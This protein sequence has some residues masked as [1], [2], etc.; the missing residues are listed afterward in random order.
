MG[1]WNAFS[2]GFA[3]WIAT[4]A[5]VTAEM[6]YLPIDFTELKNQNRDL[7]INGGAFPTGNQ[8]YAGV[9]FRLS[10]G[11][12]Y[13]W[14]A[15][16]GSNPRVLEIPVKVAGVREVHTLMNT[17]CGSPGPQSYAAIEFVGTGGAKHTVSLIGNVDIRDHHENDRFTSKINGTTT[18]EAFNSGRGQRLDKQKFVLP[19]AF[20]TDTLRSIRLIDT[21]GRGVQRIFLVAVTV[22]TETEK[23]TPGASND[24]QFIAR[25]EKAM[26]T[27]RKRLLTAIDKRVKDIRSSN[28]G[29]DEKRLQIDAIQRDRNAFA[30]TGSLPSSNELIDVEISY[31]NENQRIL[32][33][34]EQFR[35]AHSERAVRKDSAD[36]IHRLEELE[37]KLRSLIGGREQFVARSKWDGSREEPSSGATA[38]RLEV[39]EIA[40]NAFRGVIVQFHDGGRPERHAVTGRLDG[41][42][43]TFD[44]THA[45]EGGNRVMHCE[46]WLLSNRIISIVGW[47]NPIGQRKVGRMTLQRKP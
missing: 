20:R 40:G 26:Q 2:M 46:G 41:N 30:N 5:T 3:I 12:P 42:S 36:E 4:T 14:Y 18:M 7:L 44:I 9:P 25:Q 45:I 16:E 8:R 21:G 31:L 11:D 39:Q 24:D 38:M 6:R 35:E 32:N 22:A 28:L 19:D 10:D 23:N 37:A 47:V 27:A 33:N 29:G 17:Y 13:M 15:K 43:L 1:L 34:I